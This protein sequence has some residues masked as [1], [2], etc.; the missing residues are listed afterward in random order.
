LNKGWEQKKK[1]GYVLRGEAGVGGRGG[2]EKGGDGQ[3]KHWV[4]KT[5]QRKRGMRPPPLN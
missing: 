3:R 1:R 5:K 4:K 2:N